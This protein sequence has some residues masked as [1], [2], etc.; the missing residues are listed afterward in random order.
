MNL[1]L[2]WFLLQILTVRSSK[3][4]PY[5]SQSKSLTAALVA[6]QSL[7]TIASFWFS[8]CYCGLSWSYL[9]YPYWLWGSYEGNSQLGTPS[10]LCSA[11]PICR[12]NRDWTLNHWFEKRGINASAPQ[13][14]EAIVH[15]IKR[16]LCHELCCVYEF[17]CCKSISAFIRED[18]KRWD[19]FSSKG[20]SEKW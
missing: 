1:Q 4:S 5:H 18:G 11:N 9:L 8:Y 19:V 17:P 10:T 6:V 7:L 20:S 16:L 14:L 3:N 13:R 12:Y 2:F 15:R